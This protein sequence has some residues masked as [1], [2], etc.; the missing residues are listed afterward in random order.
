MWPKPYGPEIGCDFRGSSRL[1]FLCVR[2]GLAAMR[3]IL[4][5][6]LA[7]TSVPAAA[8]EGQGSPCSALVREFGRK[9][10]QPLVAQEQLLAEVE[11]EN[12]I[13][14][15]TSPEEIRLA[16]NEAADVINV[17]WRGSG[18]TQMLRGS[19]FRIPLSEDPVVQERWKQ[20][21]AQKP[22][23]PLKS[24]DMTSLV[25]YATGR[26]ESRLEHFV[27]VG[28]AYLQGVGHVE[29]QKIYDG[30][31][32]EAAV[33]V[34]LPATFYLQGRYVTTGERD[35]EVGSALIGIERRRLRLGLGVGYVQDRGRSNV[36]PAVDLQLGLSRVAS[37]DV[38]SLGG[39][40]DGG[41]WYRAGVG[42]HFRER[43][44][45]GGAFTWRPDEPRLRVGGDVRLNVRVAGPFWAM[46]HAYVGPVQGGGAAVGLAF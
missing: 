34:R 41:A 21:K 27:Y 3:L 13:K 39:I 23:G 38:S 22:V 9:L 42:L 5:L 46:A 14:K 30:P 4:F 35:F 1:T 28:G 26:P 16:M 11:C 44:D 6:I 15:G 2:L 25:R 19:F 37:I 43:I 33:R 40:G 18:Q 10:V 8:T 24:R 12:E 17:V 7:G 36:Q 20:Y 31:E 32:L 45:L 29:D